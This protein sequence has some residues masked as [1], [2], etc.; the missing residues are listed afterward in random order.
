MV[1]QLAE[2]EFKAKTISEWRVGGRASRDNP[3]AISG[4]HPTAHKMHGHGQRSAIALKLLFGYL[5]CTP[6]N[7]VVSIAQKGWRFSTRYQG[8]GELLKRSLTSKTGTYK[9]IF[10]SFYK[11]A[12]SS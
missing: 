6:S 7:I 9:P 3:P 4:L 1:W 2:P 5:N 10:F 8:G 12:L 11:F